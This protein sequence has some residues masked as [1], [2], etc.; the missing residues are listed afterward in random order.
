MEGVNLI[1]ILKALGYFVQALKFGMESIC[2]LV[3][4]LHQGDFL[5][6]I[7]IKDAYLHVPMSVKY[8][9]FLHFVVGDTH[10]QFEL[11]PFDLAFALRVFTM[12]LALVLALP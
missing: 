10:Y 11:L 7:V 9:C 3:A 6:S 8:Q 2:L 12:V 5:A 4:S 1:L